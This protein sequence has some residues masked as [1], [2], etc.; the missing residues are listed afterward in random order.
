VNGKKLG[1][2]TMPKNGHLKW[3]AI[4]QPGKVVAIGYKNGKRILKETIETTKPATKIVLK[5]DRQTINADGRDVS[6][7]TVEVQDKNGRIVPDACP[8]LTFKLEGDSRILGVGNGDPSYMGEDH[9]KAKDCRAFSI[10]AFNGLAQV[11]IQS[12]CMPS[13]LKLTATGDGLTAGS[14]SLNTK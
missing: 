8:T 1:R 13:S 3:K 9:P 7:I 4:Y 10:P 5:A 14:I 2:Q 11:L 12:S 6:V